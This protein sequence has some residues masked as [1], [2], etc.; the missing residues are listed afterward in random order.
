[1][2]DDEPSHVHKLHLAV[3]SFPVVVRIQPRVSC[4]IAPHHHDKGV[5]IAH[6]AIGKAQLE[7]ALHRMPSE[8]GQDERH[9]L[10]NESAQ[11][12]SHAVPRRI[13]TA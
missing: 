10:P 6:T 12:R 1:M 2:V 9:G 3:E 13:A 7:G 4:R 8:S 11:P 5:L